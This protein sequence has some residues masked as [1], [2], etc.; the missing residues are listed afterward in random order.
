LC[1]I[2]HVYVFEEFPIIFFCCWSNIIHFP[3]LAAVTA[4]VVVVVVPAVGVT[5]PAS[6]LVSTS[7]PPV[8]RRLKK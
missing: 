5:E 1:D 2:L 8:A 6:P 3:P 7:V 4:V